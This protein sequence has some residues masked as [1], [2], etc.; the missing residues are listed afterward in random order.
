MTRPLTPSLPVHAQETIQRFLRSHNR[1]AGRT[2]FVIGLSGGIDSAL[3]VRLARDAVGAPG[4]LGVLMPDSLFPP[5]LIQETQAYAQSLGVETRVVPI[6]GPEQAFHAAL[7]DVADRVAWG[8]IKAR[9]RMILLYALASQHQRL[10]L[11]TGNKSE[12][13]LGYFTKFGD[14]GADL[15]PLGDLYKTQVREMARDL[16]LPRVVQE[17]PPTAGLWEGQT[18]EAELGLPYTE[19]D[20]ILVGLERLFTESEIAERTGQPAEVVRA[21]VARVAEN[22]HKRRLPPIPKLS[23]RTVGVDWRD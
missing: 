17:R 21:I 13:L 10:V 16:Q 20:R 7:P 18:D 5:E 6:D 9:I 19:L 8:N 2:G 11:G 4:V 12:I 22:R 15:L 1:E 3:A 23:L 14:G